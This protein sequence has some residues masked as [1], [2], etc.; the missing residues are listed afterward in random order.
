MNDAAT[1]LAE[2]STCRPRPV[3]FLRNHAASTAELA[4]RPVT[5]SIM[6]RISTGGPSA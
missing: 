6:C 5:W 1:S 4:A 2:M 3:R